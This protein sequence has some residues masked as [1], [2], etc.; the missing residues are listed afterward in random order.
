MA[1]K[2][3]AA[4]GVSERGI[5][6]P[7]RITGQRRCRRGKARLTLASWARFARSRRYAEV[8]P[9]PETVW[10]N[11]FL[12]CEKARL[13]AET[14]G[15]SR[16]TCWQPA[17]MVVSGLRANGDGVP[18]PRAP[19]PQN[20]PDNSS[21]REAAATVP[22]KTNPAHGPALARSSYFRVVR[23]GPLPRKMSGCVWTKRT[24]GV[25]WSCGRRGSFPDAA[26]R[27]RSSARSP[28]FH[29]H[30]KIGRRVAGWRFGRRQRKLNDLT[31]SLCNF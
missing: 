18:R 2:P 15:S 21:P 5:K 17:A 28:N 7:R 8:S 19:R 26:S 27:R 31:I 1:T 11:L 6:S 20:P 3:V 24:L 12:H 23:P 22:R 4:P 14:R 30:C 29:V 10:Q 9:I 13:R 25:R 16:T